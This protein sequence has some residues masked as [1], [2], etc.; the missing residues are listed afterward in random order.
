MIHYGIVREYFC[1]PERSEGSCLV[2][3][4]SKTCYNYLE[5]NFNL[6]GR[7][8]FDGDVES[9]VASRC[10]QTTEKV[11]QTINDNNNY[12]FAA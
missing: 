4:I 3:I 8:G 2:D 1:H 5:H 9:G 12:A 11:A 7:T 10:R 6:W